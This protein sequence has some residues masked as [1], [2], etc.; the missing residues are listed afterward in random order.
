MTQLNSDYGAIVLP[1]G[2]IN[3]LQ[4]PPQHDEPLTVGTLIHVL[5]SLPM[6]LPVVTGTRFIED[7]VGRLTRDDV[8]DVI[9]NKQVPRYYATFEPELHGKRCIIL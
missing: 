9:A 5:Q 2:L 8:E 3:A 4:I 6:D 7:H 1:T